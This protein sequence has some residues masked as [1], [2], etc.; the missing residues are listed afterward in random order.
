MSAAETPRTHDVPLAI[1]VLN[2]AKEMAEQVGQHAEAFHI[3]Q[4]LE[5]LG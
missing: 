5:E 2:Q 4:L 1:K 3:D